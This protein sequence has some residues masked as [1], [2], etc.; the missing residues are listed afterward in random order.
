MTRKKKKA[1][2]EKDEVHKRA[3]IL[4]KVPQEEGREGE[5]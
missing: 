5:K 4:L 2:G 1:K 3:E